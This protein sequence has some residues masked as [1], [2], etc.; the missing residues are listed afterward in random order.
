MTKHM[1]C[2]N[3]HVFVMTKIILVAAPANDSVC[4]SVPVATRP[5]AAGVVEVFCHGR[6]QSFAA[7][8][9]RTANQ[10]GCS[11]KAKMY[12]CCIIIGR[13][14]ISLL[15]LC[16]IPGHCNVLNRYRDIS[17]EMEL[18]THFLYCQAHL[19]LHSKFPLKEHLCLCDL[20]EEWSGNRLLRV[21]VH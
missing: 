9:W 18:S 5:K 17:L 4:Q 1:F 11:L 21:E 8:H 6:R 14:T 19:H 20:R 16:H 10:A 3:K 13:T 7:H 12:S 2:C 15:H